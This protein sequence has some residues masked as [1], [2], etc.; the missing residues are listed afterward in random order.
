MHF[1]LFDVRWV[2]ALSLAFAVRPSL[3]VLAFSSDRCWR[4]GVFIT[5]SAAVAIQLFLYFGCVCMRWAVT[6]A[7]KV[8]NRPAVHFF[9]V[10]P[11]WLWQT[12]GQLTWK[13]IWFE[14]VLNFPCFEF[15]KFVEFIS[16][17]RFLSLPIYDNQ[18]GDAFVAVRLFVSHAFFRINTESYERIWTKFSGSRN[19]RHSWKHFDYEQLCVN[20]SHKPNLTW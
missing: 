19:F 9:T 17:V 4:A 18:E 13:S 14:S 3:Y 12:F 1:T 11:I 5:Q 20:Q 15:K 16:S 2:M 7:G 6:A 10:R 8:I